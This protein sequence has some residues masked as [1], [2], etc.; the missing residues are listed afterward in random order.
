MTASDRLAA[1]GIELPTVAAPA[2]VYTPAVQTGHLVYTSGQLPLVA[3]ELGARGLLGREVSV[4][5][6]QRQARTAALNA[7]AA[8]ASV[9]G[10]VDN[11]ARVVKVVVFV[12]GT[13]EFD[14]QH[15]VANGASDVL[16][17]I[18]GRPH[19]RSAVGVAALPMSAPVEVELIVEAAADAGF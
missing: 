3:G 11:L 15:V 12:A 4:E 14:Q 17:E 6:G 7:V 9:V 16:G 18:F 8:A 5:E 2:G 10:G 13:P 19:T 1:A